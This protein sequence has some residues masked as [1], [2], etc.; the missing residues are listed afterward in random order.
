MD[1]SRRRSGRTARSP[2]SPTRTRSLMCCIRSSATSSTWTG[3]KLRLV[4]ALD[5]SIFQSELIVSEKNFTRA[6]P[7][8]QG[9]RYFL[10]DGPPA[11]GAQLEEALADYGFDVVSTAQRLAGVSSRRKYLPVDV[12]GAG[13]IG[14]AA[15]NAGAG[16]GA[17]AQCDGTEE[18]TGAA[19]RRRLPAG[20]F[21]DHGDRGERFPA[22]RRDSDRGGVRADRDRAGVFRSAAAICRIRRWRCCC[23]RCRW[24]EWPLRWPRCG[25][26]R[27]RRC[28]K[29][30]GRSSAE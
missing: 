27:G 3:V 1:A 5:D 4:A 13:R 28:S 17:A 7:E 12:S 9:F 29:H 2:P 30:C 26:W 16:R 6:F 18:R 11:I 10:I 25:R 8:E 23:W 22:D 24:R 19:A 15:R 21:A 20:A 14:I